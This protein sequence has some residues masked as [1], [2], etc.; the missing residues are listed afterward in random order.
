[1][2]SLNGFEFC[3]VSPHLWCEKF[4]LS[5]LKHARCHQPETVEQWEL[6]WWPLQFFFMHVTKRQRMKSKI[7]K[8]IEEK[9]HGKLRNSMYE[10][11][12][13]NI[14]VWNGV[15]IYHHL[16]REEVPTVI[17]QCEKMFH[18]VLRPAK[19]WKRTFQIDSSTGSKK[20]V[21]KTM[22]TSFSCNKVLAE[23]HESLRSTGCVGSS[24]WPQISHHFAFPLSSKF[25]RAKG[26][27]SGPMDVTSVA[28]QFRERRGLCRSVCGKRGRWKQSQVSHVLSSEQFS[29]NTWCFFLAFNSASIGIA[30]G[31]RPKKC[32]CWPESA[33]SQR[34]KYYTN[35]GMLFYDISNLKILMSKDSRGCKQNILKKWLTEALK[36]R[37]PLHQKQAKKGIRLPYYVQ[38]QILQKSGI[39]EWVGRLKDAWFELVPCYMTPECL[40]KQIH[41]IDT[42]GYIISICYIL[43]CTNSCWDRLNSI[44]PGPGRLQFLRWASMRFFGSVCPFRRYSPKP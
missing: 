24:F 30:F 1:M 11:N 28:L 38:D 17:S 25:N 6:L 43:G 12:R 10:E 40:R 22:M 26:C 13:K 15:Y 37:F 8:D 14:N 31:G 23:T 4:W 44:K 33:A 20:S 16:P 29:S 35:I 5:P 39:V 34:S 41:G 36:N 3:I 27:A 32:L 7:S 19:L 2:P 42:R 9:I 18:R 21:S